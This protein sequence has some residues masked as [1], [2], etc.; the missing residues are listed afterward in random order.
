MNFAGHRGVIRRFS[1]AT[2]VGIIIQPDST[3]KHS[4]LWTVH[5]SIVFSGY[6]AL[7]YGKK[8]EGMSVNALADLTGQIKKV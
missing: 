4:N 7:K 8:Q 6:I 3:V 2:H 5:G 1:I